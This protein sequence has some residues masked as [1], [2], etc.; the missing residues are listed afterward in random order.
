MI[1]SIRRSPHF[2]NEL[3]REI[4]RN[5]HQRRDKDTLLSLAL[6]SRVWRHEGQRVLFSS[7]SNDWYSG[8]NTTTTHVLFL[9]SI[10]AH[11][12]RLGPY[13][14]LYAQERHAVNPASESSMIR[15]SSAYNQHR[16][17]HQHV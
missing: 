11:P 13:V 16:D 15:I 4:A 10:L 3:Y 1:D 7:L 2:P 6:V 12:N 5:L 8:L 17:S 14:H 9:Q